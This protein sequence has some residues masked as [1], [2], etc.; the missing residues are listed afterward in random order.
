MKVKL[1]FI[2]LKYKNKE[3]IIIDQTKLPHKIVYKKLKNYKQLGNS[4]K[5]LEISGGNS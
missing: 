1:K 5:K 4:I 3:I 2:P